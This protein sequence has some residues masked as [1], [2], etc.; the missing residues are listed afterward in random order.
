MVRVHGVDE[1]V[2]IRGQGFNSRQ[3][4]VPADRVESIPKM[5]F[6]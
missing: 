4:L 5:R 6:V 1:L 3:H 2:D